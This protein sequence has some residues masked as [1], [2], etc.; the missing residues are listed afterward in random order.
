MEINDFVKNFAEQFDETAPEEFKSDTNFRDLEEW[1]SFNALSIIAMVDE[2][3][4]V[5]ITGD[6]IINSHT[7]QDIFNLVKERSK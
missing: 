3:Y 2:A 6:D 1:S 5:K 7:I 4:S